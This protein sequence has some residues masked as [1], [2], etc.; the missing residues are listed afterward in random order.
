MASGY[1]QEAGT[2]SAVKFGDGYFIHLP[3]DPRFLSVIT[4]VLDPVSAIQGA[5]Q[6]KFNLAS[7]TG[8]FVYCISDHYITLKVRMVMK[9]GSAIPN[10]A[11]AA[12]KDDPTTSRIPLVAPV[13]LNNYVKITK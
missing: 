1:V 5:S 13:M 12:T 7:Q 11:K 4:Q 10:I 8:P 3:T 6:I 2:F 9:D